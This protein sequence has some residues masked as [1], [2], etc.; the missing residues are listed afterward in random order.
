MATGIRIETIKTVNN[1][2]SVSTQTNEIQINT[3]SHNNHTHCRAKI[4]G[5]SCDVATETLLSLLDGL[6]VAIATIIGQHESSQHPIQWSLPL[7]TL[8]GEAGGNSAEQLLT[9]RLVLAVEISV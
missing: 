4:H 2:I 8:P 7:L 9:K 1:T 6:F 5:N 3:F